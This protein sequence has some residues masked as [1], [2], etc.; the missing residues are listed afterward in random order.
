MESKSVS[1]RPANKGV[2]MTDLDDVI[3]YV[4]ENNVHPE[5]LFT[6]LEL[7]EAMEYVH[8]DDIDRILEMAEPDEKIDPT[9]YHDNNNNHPGA[10]RWCSDAFC[11]YYI[12]RQGS[13]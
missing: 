11:Q 2:V 1:S 13:L 8:V 9:D 5:M 4:R 6:A 12:E 7:R 10:I 3:A